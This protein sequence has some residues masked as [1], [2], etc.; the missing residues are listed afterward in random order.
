MAGAVSNVE[1][2]NSPGPDNR[3]SGMESVASVPAS[4]PVIVPLSPPSRSASEFSIVRSASAE[5]VQTPAKVEGGFSA[6]QPGRSSADETL[7]AIASANSSPSEVSASPDQ[8]RALAAINLPIGPGLNSPQASSRFTLTPTKDPTDL[9]TPKEV[10]IEPGEGRWA[11]DQSGIGLIGEARPGET[12]ELPEPDLAGMIQSFLPF[13]RLAMEDAVDRFLEPFEGLASSM[14][15]LRGPM[16]LITASLAA[17]AT[18]V[19]VE[20]AIRLRRAREEELGADDV[21]GL[22]SFP[23][24]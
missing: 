1:T 4:P 21:E 11:V 6:S 7:L 20:V 23:G 9:P 17:A 24:L 16:G 22:T 8:A 10:P 13:D 3:G 12:I 2:A 19:A 15:E 18:V 14:P 5:L